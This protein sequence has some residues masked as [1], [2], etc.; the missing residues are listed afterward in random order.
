MA[1]REDAANG[2]HDPRARCDQEQDTAHYKPG[3]PWRVAACTEPRN[4]ADNEHEERRRVGGEAEYPEDVGLL[5]R[6]CAERLE[7]GHVEERDAHEAEDAEEHEQHG[8][9]G[10]PG[11]KEPLDGARAYAVP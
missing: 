11:S 10:E 6:R 5:T 8:G 3:D 1:L 9:L 4:E 7:H 2:R